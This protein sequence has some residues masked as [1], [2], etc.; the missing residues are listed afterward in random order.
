MT[1]NSRRTGAA[2]EANYRFVV[3][4][5]ANHREISQEPQI[6]DWEFANSN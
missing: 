5:G 2:I 3:W 4:L 6:H 1:D